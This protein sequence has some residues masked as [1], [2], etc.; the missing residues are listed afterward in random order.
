MQ[1]KTLFTIAHYVL[2]IF[3]TCKIVDSFC[4]NSKC[5]TVDLIIA[6]HVGSRYYIILVLTRPWILLG[7]SPLKVHFKTSAIGI[8]FYW[9]SA[10]TMTHG[11]DERF[12]KNLSYKISVV[13]D[14]IRKFWFQRILFLPNDPSCPRFD[15]N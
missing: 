6:C 4:S 5:S 10:G 9:C 15:F 7:M 12:R 14:F 1:L 13:W 11:I 2:R 3:M 8:E